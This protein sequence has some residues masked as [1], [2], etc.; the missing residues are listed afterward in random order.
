MRIAQIAPLIESVPPKL[1]GGT[2]RVIS[3]LTEELVKL[4]HDVT[5]FASGDSTTNSRLIGCH[6]RAIRLD[7]NAFVDP[8]AHHLLMLERINEM[9]TSFDIIHF[10]FGYLHLPYTRLLKTAHLTTLHDRL[11]FVHFA[12]FYTAFP[13]V[14]V[15]SISDAQRKPLPW[16][17]WIET[18]YH[19]LPEN[20]YSLQENPGDYLL[21]VGRICPEKRVDRAI[22]IALRA[23]RKLVIAAKVDKVDADYYESAIKP[24]LK[25]SQVEYIGEVSDKEKNELFGNAYALIHAIEFPEPFGLTMIESLACGTPVIAF[26]HG[27]IPEV[28]EDGVTGFVCDDVN[29]AVTAVASIEKLTRKR[30]RAR[31]VERFTAERM[32]KNYISVYQAICESRPQKEPGYLSLK[33]Q[34]AAV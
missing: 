28:I 15:V 16:L 31:F 30:C 18:I 7:A 12:P 3:W 26:R 4:G 14:P 29:A 19:G 20:Q 23:G 13:K 17:N 1:Y 11:D 5:L 9:A 8:T 32:A 24:L 33:N 25:S 10:H 21:F 34:S 2:E 27:S 6:P 22:E